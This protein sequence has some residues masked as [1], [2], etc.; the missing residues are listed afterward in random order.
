MGYFNYTYIHA[1]L[2]HMCNVHNVCYFVYGP[3][4][5]LPGPII[6]RVL[7]ALK[8]NTE[9]SFSIFAPMYIYIYL[10]VRSNCS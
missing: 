1:A 10:S 7:P 6:Y 2:K 9:E 4:I 5:I 3:Y 8:I